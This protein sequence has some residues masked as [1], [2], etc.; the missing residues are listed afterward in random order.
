VKRTLLAALLVLALP[1]ARAAAGEKLVVVSCNFEPY[2]GESLKDVGPLARLTRMA[3]ENAGYEVDLRIYPWARVLK[4][5]EAGKVDVIFGMW[6]SP[7]R[8]AWV[9]FSDPLADNEIG[10]YKRRGEALAF[11]SMAELKAARVVVGSVRGYANPPVVGSSGVTLDEASDDEANVKKL[12][13]GRVKVALLDR[14]IG[15]FLAAR[16]GKGQEL[17]WLTTL[18][19]KPL[20]DGVVKTSGKDWKK[21]LADLN[22]ELAALKAKGVTAQVLKEGGL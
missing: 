21:I 7:E 19:R 10:L 12:L 15:S 1:A 16:L 8:E 4:E 22:R 3:L 18:E 6:R 11:V 13:A 17:E 5:G 9:A 20:L 2:F 14:G